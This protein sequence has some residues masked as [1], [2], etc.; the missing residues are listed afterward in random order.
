MTPEAVVTLFR[1]EMGDRVEPFL[2][3]NDDVLAYLN[4][5]YF[6]FVRGMGGVADV[7][8]I[9]Y[10]ANEAFSEV[11]VDVLTYRYVYHPDSLRKVELR[12]I[13]EEDHALIL[14]CTTLDAGRPATGLLGTIN[15]QIR[16]TPPPLVSGILE[17]SV[18]RMPSTE[19]PE[20]LSGTFE[21]EDRYHRELVSGM[22]A[23]ALLKQDAETFNQRRADIQQALFDK[24][25][26]DAKSER[27]RALHNPRLIAYGGI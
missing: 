26:L 16:W 19:I 23:Q 13:E 2:W 7:I 5:A 3:S 4:Y 24:H 21:L 6:A 9:P 20:G 14:R 8:E 12:N 11:P 15:G 1:S 27:A 18:Y 22:A 17:A 10:A 25:I